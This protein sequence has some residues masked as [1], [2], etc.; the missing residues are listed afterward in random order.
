MRRQFDVCRYGSGSATDDAPYICILQ[1]HYLQGME[2]VLVAP[3]LRGTIPAT[4]S[5]VAVPVRIG[6]VDYVLDPAL[7]ATMETRNVGPVVGSLA[8]QEF[9]IRRALDRLFTGF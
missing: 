3:L 4:P 1:S 2:T 7:M 6:D 8:N 5:Q 9:E